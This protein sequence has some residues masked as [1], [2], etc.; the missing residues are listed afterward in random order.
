MILECDSPLL[1]LT[2]SQMQKIW[3]LWQEIFT[4][5]MDNG[6]DPEK[7]L[8]LLRIRSLFKELKASSNLTT[9]LTS[10]SSNGAKTES[11]TKS[12]FDF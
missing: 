11:L 4:Y 10:A 5:P 9:I 2:E 8:K 12:K 6:E 7:E 1:S 3:K